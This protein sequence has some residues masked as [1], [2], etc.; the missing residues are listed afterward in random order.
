MKLCF[1]S[2]TPNAISLMTWAR[3]D[4]GT[5]LNVEALLF[6]SSLSTTADNKTFSTTQSEVFRVFS[7]KSSFLDLPIS[8]VL[9]SSAYRK[10]RQYFCGCLWPGWAALHRRR[11]RH[12]GHVVAGGPTLPRRE[13]RRLSVK[14]LAALA[15]NY[16]ADGRVLGADVHR[17]WQLWVNV[18]VKRSEE[19]QNRCCDLLLL[20]MDDGSDRSAD[21]QAKFNSRNK[22]CNDTNQNPR[23]I[24]VCRRQ[25]SMRRKRIS[26]GP[27]HANMRHLVTTKAAWLFKQNSKQVR[28]M[29]TLIKTLLVFGR[30]RDHDDHRSL[31]PS[32]G[33]RGRTRWLQKDAYTSPI[34]YSLILSSLAKKYGSLLYA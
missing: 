2:A 19:E 28:S 3:L 11:F 17:H 1:L 20:E 7:S 16:H 25:W 13:L 26:Q 4:K 27:N 9:N 33:W 14:A 21:N 15:W 31:S 23:N 10:S 24:A 32:E 30:D 6:F 18:T 5:K 8:F 34:S 22:A 29:P 12:C